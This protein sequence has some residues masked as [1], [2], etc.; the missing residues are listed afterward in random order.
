MKFE[1]GDPGNAR[2]S[3]HGMNLSCR[4]TRGRG[5]ASVEIAADQEPFAEERIREMIGWLEVA[6]S[7]VLVARQPELG[8]AKTFEEAMSLANERQRAAFQAFIDKL[9]DA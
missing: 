6:L 9:G 1:Y 3:L 2:S 8:P 5:L 4:I 7:E